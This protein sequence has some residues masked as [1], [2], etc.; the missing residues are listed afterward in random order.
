MRTNIFDKLRFFEDN[1]IVID[2]CYSPI[3]KKRNI[4]N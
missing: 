3:G 1:C 4:D 2:D